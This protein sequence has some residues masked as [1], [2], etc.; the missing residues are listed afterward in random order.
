[1]G[2]GCSLELR[3]ETEIVGDPDKPVVK[4]NNARDREKRPVSEHR[5][6]APDTRPGIPY[7]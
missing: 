3:T 1:M 7:Y 4:I 5:L 2:P 6:P